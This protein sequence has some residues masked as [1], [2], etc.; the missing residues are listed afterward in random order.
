MRKPHP[1]D[2]A[3]SPPV[4]VRPLISATIPAGGFPLESA[5]LADAIAE[6]EAVYRALAPLQVK[7]T[8]LES[9]TIG[10][11]T[12]ADW[13]PL[14]LA[15][16]R[17]RKIAD[18]THNRIRRAVDRFAI[19]HGQSPVSALLSGCAGCCKTNHPE[20]HRSCQPPTGVFL[21]QTLNARLRE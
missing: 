4:K 12:V 3:G 5:T 17:A 11:D 15:R 8:L 13:I 2:T 6:V 9:V 16:V 18:E 7:R 20:I 1:A 19:E 21:W 10:P 14:Y